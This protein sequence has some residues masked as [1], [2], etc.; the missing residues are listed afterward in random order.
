MRFHGSVTFLALVALAFAAAACA[1]PTPSVVPSGSPDGTG[2]PSAVPSAPASPGPSTISFALRTFPWAQEVDG[3]PVGCDT[4]GVAN[5]VFGHLAGA[6]AI[7]STDPIWLEAPDGSRLSIVWPEG[8]TLEF[9]PAPVIYDQTGAE[10]ARAGDAVM[11]QVS[12]ADAAGRR[13]DPYFASGILLAGSFTA[14][15]ISSGVAYQGCFPRVADVSVAT[16]WVD[17][18]AGAL[19][20]ETTVIPAIISEQA[21]ASGQSPEGRVLDP[22]IEYRADAVVVTISVTKRIG[23][24]DCPGNPDFPIEIKLAEPLGERALLDGGSIPPRDATTT[25]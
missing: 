4:I 2:G 7:D 14:D 17:P 3:T 1:A 20:A 25:P 8:F 16:W 9:E 15:D 6:F 21:C 11:L 13:D 22:V 24:Q 5:P 12:R 19:S 23:G 10:V 18:V